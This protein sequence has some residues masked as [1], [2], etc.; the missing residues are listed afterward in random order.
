MPCARATANALLEQLGIEESAVRW[1]L[2]TGRVDWSDRRWGV[3]EI[4]AHD[5]GSA[6]R[7][8]RDL[9]HGWCGPLA[10]HEHDELVVLRHE[11]RRL[12][13]LAVEAI[14]LLR[15]SNRT[16]ADRLARELGITG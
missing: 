10:A 7:P 11:M 8:A 9:V 13:I 1:R 2:A 3:D 4:L 16:Q 12:G 14:A 15:R 6:G 5:A